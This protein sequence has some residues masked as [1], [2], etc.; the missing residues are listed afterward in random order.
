[1]PPNFD[2]LQKSEVIEVIIDD[3]THGA[4]EYISRC[5]V[6]IEIKTVYTEHRFACGEPIPLEFANVVTYGPET[7]A[8]ATLLS[9]DGIVSENRLSSFFAEVTNGL[10]SPTES[11]INSFLCEAADNADTESL[12]ESVLKESIMHVD[13][14]PV[15]CTERPEEDK[16]GNITKDEDGTPK[17]ETSEHKSFNVCIRTY[18]NDTTT[19]LTVNGHKNN[20]GVIRDGILPKYDDIVVQ[21]FE[22]KFLKYG[23]AT[24]LC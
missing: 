2:E 1:L 6:D 22:A 17:M 19:L 13:D 4:S 14:T 11:T 24:A 12:K 8:V 7:K 23:A 5:T 15:R 20:A 9:V 21:D 3:R 16:Q 18:R 10:V